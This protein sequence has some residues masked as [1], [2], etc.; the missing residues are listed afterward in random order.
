MDTY[1]NLYI[2]IIVPYEVTHLKYTILYIV[3]K[4]NIQESNI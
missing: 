2:K 4:Y 1:L 3:F